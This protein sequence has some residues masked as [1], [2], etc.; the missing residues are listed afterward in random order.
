SES[1]GLRNRT[2]PD[3]ADRQ[4]DR[5]ATRFLA[6]LACA[7]V[8]LAAPA[9]ATDYPDGPLTLSHGFAPGGAVDTIA[10]VLANRMERDLGR[11]I[12]VEA[13]PGLT[14]ML[15]AA[16]VAKAAPDGRR[17]LVLPAAYPAHG[18]LS[19][20]GRF[21]V[22]DFTWISTLSVTPLAIAVRPGSPFRTPGDLIA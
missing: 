1:G 17:L 2:V 3:H 15:A 7:A 16:A 11:A 10:N 20:R 19:P 14:G 4:E 21:S 13:K 5:I 18:T 12:A 8:A 9:E 6:A 22:D